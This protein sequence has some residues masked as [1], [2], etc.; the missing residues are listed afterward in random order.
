MLQLAAAGVIFA[1]LSHQRREQLRDGLLIQLAVPSMIVI[2]SLLALIV[3]ARY[4]IWK[5]G[6][7]NEAQC[8]LVYPR[9]EF[10]LFLP[11]G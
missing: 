1:V 9:F 6:P 10:R 5:L 11:I 7:A 8:S 4:S 2:S 3:A